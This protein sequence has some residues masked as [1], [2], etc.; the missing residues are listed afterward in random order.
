[1][2]SHNNPRRTAFTVV[3]LLM[4]I[5]II[6]ILIALLLPALN[7]TRESA[8]RSLCSA[9]QKM[10][11][12][13]CNAY[14]ETRRQ[15]PPGAF[16]AENQKLE[17]PIGKSV[18]GAVGKSPAPYSFIVKLLPYVELAHIYEEIDF[19][20]DAFDANNREYANVMLPI[21]I[22]PS[23]TGSPTSTAGEYKGD[24]KPALSNYKSVAAT[25]FA[26]WN[27]KDAVLDSKG[28]GGAI[29]PY[30]SVRA[31]QATSQTVFICET[32]EEKYAAWF[33]GATGTMP[34]F[35]PEV[36]KV[37]K[38]TR[39]ALNYRTEKNPV[40]MSKQRFGGS[41]DMT[42]G[43]SSEHG[44]LV[45]HSF[46]DTHTRAISDDVDAEVYAALITRRWDDNGDIGDFFER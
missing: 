7:T 33:D 8:R 15:F 6:G 25:T 12:L 2:L 41:A 20:K 34:G 37:K 32:R 3:E 21:V 42:W 39:P 10:L 26:V 46:G 23:F 27:D 40:F 45:I 13:S 4:V 30:G 19:K 22:C 44:G 36:D 31:L 9:N 35:H 1:M 43:P 17:I 29:H 24:D 28:D 16:L 18:P 38:A 5:A 14:Y 11:T